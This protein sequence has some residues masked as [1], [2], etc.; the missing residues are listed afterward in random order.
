M[1]TGRQRV[2]AQKGEID[3]P[4]VWSESAERRERQR[5][6]QDRRQDDAPGWEAIKQKSDAGRDK[7]YGDRRQCECA[8]DGLPFPSK[9]SMQR[10]QEEAERVQDDRSKA[11]HH[12][13]KCG[14]HHAPANVVT[15]AFARCLRGD[16]LVHR[17]G[18]SS[19]P[20]RRAIVA[21]SL[22]PTPGRVRPCHY[23]AKANGARRGTHSLF[24]RS[25]ILRN[26]LSESR[27]NRRRN[28]R[29]CLG[30]RPGYGLARYPCG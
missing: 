2:P 27:S 20:S 26:L 3:L 1:Q 14:G 7:S 4:D 16:C 22:G 6:D 23:L 10:I 11:H 29:Q 9:R 25:G 8:T 17:L 13:C 12:S 5:E 28:Q 30:R 24:R 15:R 18:A 21:S 19:R